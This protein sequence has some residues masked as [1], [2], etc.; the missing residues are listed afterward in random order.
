MILTTDYLTHAVLLTHDV[1]IYEIHDVKTGVHN[2]YDWFYAHDDKCLLLVVNESHD[3]YG[4]EVTLDWNDSR[5]F[6]GIYEVDGENKMN[7][8]VHNGGYR[9]ECSVCLNFLWIVHCEG[10]LVCHFWR[11]KNDFL[12]MVFL[13][14]W[15]WRRWDYYWLQKL[16]KARYLNVDLDSEEVQIY[17]LSLLLKES[18]TVKSNKS[19]NRI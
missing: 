12:G 4:C 7:S 17:Y 2:C 9:H 14:R 11:T 18:S 3:L 19:A 16:L 5:G 13:C 6:Y 1:G 10:F 15:W 8:Y